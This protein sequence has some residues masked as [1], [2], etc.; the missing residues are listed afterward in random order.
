MLMKSSGD[1][2]IR[3]NKETDYIEI[4]LNGAW[5]PYENTHLSGEYG[6]II[7]ETESLNTESV[8]CAMG[9]NI[10]QGVFLGG[11][12]VFMVTI[13]GEYTITCGDYSTNAIAIIG[14]KTSVRLDSPAITVTIKSD[15]LDGE[16][17][18]VSLYG[19]TTGKMCLDGTAVFTLYGTGD[20][21]IFSTNCSAARSIVYGESYEITLNRP[22]ATLNLTT[23][24]LDGEP[25]TVV[26]ENT[27]Y[28]SV[29]PCSMKVYNFGTA[30]I[31]AGEASVTQEVVSGQTYEIE[32]SEFV[33]VYLM[34]NGVINRSLA[35]FN[36]NQGTGV[37]CTVTDGKSRYKVPATY[38]CDLINFSAPSEYVGRTLHIKAGPIWCPAKL[39]FFEYGSTAN[40][41][42]IYPTDK[43]FTVK[44]PNTGNFRV[45]FENESS[46]GDMTIDLIDVYVV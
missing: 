5:V 30:T 17:I 20:I 4:L 12:C 6:T 31:T 14:Q 46:S 35:S 26:I 2:S 22:Y 37:T 9:D 18:Y 43:E 38:T 19:K 15:T 32:V 42:Y 44:I 23:R 3:Y 34:S 24:D 27:S 13:P 36:T 39:K 28:T 21:E 7:V 45:R 33:P 8:T 41:Q 25:V 10:F 40:T 29:L 16:M 11:S 1:G